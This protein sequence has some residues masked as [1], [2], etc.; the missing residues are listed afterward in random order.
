MGGG[1]DVMSRGFQKLSCHDFFNC[2]ISLYVVNVDIILNLYNYFFFGTHSFIE[3]RALALINGGHY[4]IINF[5]KA[6]N[7]KSLQRK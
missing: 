2:I 7:K 5:I 6:I 4:T 3:F 1:G